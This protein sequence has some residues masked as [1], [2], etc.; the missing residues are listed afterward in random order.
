MQL[1]SLLYSMKIKFFGIAKEIV[2]TKNIWFA[3]AGSTTT[4]AD[5]K[6]WLSEQY[7]ALQKLQSFAIAVDNEYVGDAETIEKNSEVA[8]LPP[9][10]GG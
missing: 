6:H 8:V 2:G 10:S 1:L 9:V 4:V 7:P 5:L 3:N